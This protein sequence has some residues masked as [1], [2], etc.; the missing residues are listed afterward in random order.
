MRHEPHAVSDA[1]AD[2]GGLVEHLFRQHAGQLT[3]ALARRLGPAHLDAAEDIVHDALVQALR[4]WPFR[5]VP[6]D[7]RAWLVRVAH[8][9]AL[10]AARR[11]AVLRRKLPALELWVRDAA[12]P[13]AGA[14]G[15]LG[16]DELALVFACCHP[17]VP[18]E[19]GVALALKTVAGFGVGE[20]ARAFVAEEAAIAQRLVRARRRLRAG[21]VAI[22]VPEHPAEL[23]ARL[24]AVLDTL[25]LLFNEGY[26]AHGGDA[27]VRRDL[28]AE[29]VRLAL[30]V[31]GHPATA[32]PAAHALV[33]L[34]LFHAAR[35]DTRTGETGDVVLLGDQDRSRWD[36]GLIGRAFHHLA[37]AG[38]GDVLTRHHLEARIASYHA[39][40][41]SLRDTDWRGVLQAYDA[42]A[43]LVPTPV[44][45]V[46]RAVAVGM[47]HGAPAALDALDAVA[48]AP[49]MR[50][51]LWFHAARAH[52]LQ[53]AGRRAE[54]A[55]AYRRA[56]MLAAVEPARRFLDARLRELEP[57][58]PGEPSA[59]SAAVDGEPRSGR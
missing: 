40:A 42:L 56:R 32:G 31:A 50:R 25:Y 59:P 33:A 16:D 9:R 44:V 35:L 22:A 49:A 17:A 38:T 53:R 54:A 2:V 20:I 8:N 57:G 21:D 43:G 41:P 45:R 7:P 3:A 48:D 15:P 4:T 13:G 36:R 19:A 26:G 37:L 6:D 34:M 29:A 11:D 39:I 23:A 27:L 47:V 18:R 51:Y 14:D 30:L 46:H 1:R 5:G 58:A 10:D 12:V 55:A 24:P 28:C 52:W